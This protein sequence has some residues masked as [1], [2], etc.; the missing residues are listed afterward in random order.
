MI[1]FLKKILEFIGVRNVIGEERV[2]FQTFQPKSSIP[3][4]RNFENIDNNND[5]NGVPP[6]NINTIKIINTIN[7]N[8]FLMT[9]RNL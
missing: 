4:N 2:H 1:D 9:L 6:N 7:I 5:V 8:L 3:L